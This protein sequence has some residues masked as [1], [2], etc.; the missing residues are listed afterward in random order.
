V[1]LVRRGLV[2]LTAIGVLATAFE[3][4]TERDGTGSN[5]WSRG[6]PWLSSRLPSRCC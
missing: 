5:N 3:L 6:S 1:V 4:A 2:A